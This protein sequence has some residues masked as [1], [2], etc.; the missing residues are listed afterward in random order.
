[1]ARYS[2]HGD[3]VR[4]R[5]AELVDRGYGRRSI[6]RELGLPST[7]VEKLVG[8][9]RRQGIEGLVSM[10]TKKF[11]APELKLEAVLAYLG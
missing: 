7:T 8:Q 5:L 6:A 9:Y 1:M 4:G 3:E 2:R 11:Y 10:A